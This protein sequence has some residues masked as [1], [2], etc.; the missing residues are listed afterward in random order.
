MLSLVTGT[1]AVLVDGA[2][3]AG[4]L[5]SLLTSTIANTSVTF[6]HLWGT[7]VDG[8]VSLSRLFFWLAFWMRTPLS[9]L[10][11]SRRFGRGWGSLR[12]LA[13][14]MVANPPLAPLLATPFLAPPAVLAPSASS[15]TLR[16]H[17]KQPE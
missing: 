9:D 11:H 7:F 15:S 4:L 10:S 2:A 3:I 14:L 17:G 1:E 8:V 12:S 13:N 5:K 6:G 16:L